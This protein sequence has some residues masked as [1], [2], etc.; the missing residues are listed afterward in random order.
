MQQKKNNRSEEATHIEWWWQ[1]WREIFCSLQIITCNLC[2]T[3]KSLCISTSRLCIERCFEKGHTIHN[4]NKS[5]F[6][7]SLSVIYPVCMRVSTITIGTSFCFHTEN[8]LTIRYN[9]LD[10]SVPFRR[11]YSNKF[12]SENEQ[13][14][15]STA[16]KWICC[17]C[18]QMMFPI[19]QVQRLYVPTEM[20]LFIL[21]SI[22]FYEFKKKSECV[23]LL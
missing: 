19:E 21:S 9:Q 17:Y 4:D 3:L 22:F 12:K 6:C 23:F 13:G 1:K 2:S 11:M 20:H 8:S 18:I 16:K 7:A 14:R 5:G 10:S 15:D